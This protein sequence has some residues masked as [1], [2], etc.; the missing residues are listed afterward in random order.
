MVRTFQKLRPF[1][2]MT[3]R[4]NVM[5]SLIS[6]GFTVGEAKEKAWGYLEIVGM[7]HMADM[8]A[9]GFSTG[10]RKRLEL[11][12]AMASDPVL[13]LLDEP[14]GGIDPS[15]C[16]RVVDL[17]RRIRDEGVAIAVIEHRMR[18][19]ASIADRLVALR[20]GCKIADGAP[21]AVLND[22]EVVEAYLGG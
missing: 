22:P 8:K 17:I 19:L 13:L 20:A 5:V 1:A 12:R 9:M 3:A 16:S 21:E 6:D 15:G 7:S 11:A 18:V 2:S 10:Q 4:E 14:T